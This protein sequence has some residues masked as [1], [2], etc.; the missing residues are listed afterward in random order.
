MRI[1]KNFNNK[2]EKSVDFVKNFKPCDGWSIINFYSLCFIQIPRKQ[3]E[4]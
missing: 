1:R 3:T 2:S 4:T